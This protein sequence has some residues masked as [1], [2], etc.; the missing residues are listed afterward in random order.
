MAINTSYQVAIHTDAPV[1]LLSNIFGPMDVWSNSTYITRSAYP[2]LSHLRTL[3]GTAQSRAERHGYSTFGAV[4]LPTGATP[5]KDK[6]VFNVQGP[7]KCRMDYGHPTDTFM[8]TMRS[9]YHKFYAAQQEE[10]A[11]PDT[12]IIPPNEYYPK[13][14]R[15]IDIHNYYQSVAPKIVNQ[16]ADNGLEGLIVLKVEDGLVM[17]RHAHIEAM[18]ITSEE[19]LAD[20][21]RGRTVEFHFAVGP[22]TKLAWLD[23][24]PKEEFH[25]EDAKKVATELIP[26]LEDLSDVLRVEPRFSGKTGFHLICHLHSSI[27]TDE[28]RQMMKDVAETYIQKTDQMD[29]LTT[30]ATDNPRMMR[31]DYSTLHDAGGLRLTHS[32]AYPTGLICMSLG[33]EQLRNFQ[34][35]D[36]LVPATIIQQAQSLAEYQ[37]KRQFD[38]TP[39]PKGDSPT[40]VVQE[41]DAQKAGLHYDLRLEDEGVLRS[42]S[43][44]KLPALVAN[45][46]GRALA[47][48]VEDHPLAY[49]SYEGDIPLG[50]Y[51][52]GSVRIWDKVEYEPLSKGDK[53]W[54]FR[55]ASGRMKGVWVLIHMDSN[56]WLLQ[57]GK[58]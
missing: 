41:H 27:N 25:I 55:V 7:L 20:V 40:L 43:V 19:A 32:L 28:A 2:S 46:I 15:E 21:N 16:Y 38:Q 31:I 5:P 52:G 13:G 1:H 10:L 56:Q 58:E 18:D 49:A 23:L 30:K 3:V 39:E 48:Q 12:I 22:T 9:P 53:T 4:V 57:R 34:K 14:L 8:Y 33:P 17:R 51:G 36:A 11:H 44:P 45:Q 35:T 50:Q 54:K 6:T 26:R 37:Q 24:D 47:I 29:T 42:W